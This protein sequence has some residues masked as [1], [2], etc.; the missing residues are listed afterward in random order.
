MSEDTIK[1]DN[2][3]ALGG[4]RNSY[5]YLSSIINDRNYKTG[6]EIG[7]AF[8]DHC[9]YILNNTK[10][11][12][13]Y[14]IDPYFLY[15]DYKNDWNRQ[16]FSID[17]NGKDQDYFDELYSYVLNKLSI[18]GDRYTHI[19][20]VSE[21]SFKNFLDNNIDFVYI[22]GNHSREY[23]RK[24]LNNW[25]NVIKIGGIISGHDYNHSGLPEVTEEVDLFAKN[26]NKKVIYDGD[27]VWHIEK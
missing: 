16:H 11:D 2:D 1:R 4:W 24:D 10:I 18:Y 17:V 14:G 19:R 8:G 3:Y 22:D 25:W 26:I 7:V 15:D 12:K 13:L 20:D 27:H 23:I 5:K 21:K 6:V 9:G